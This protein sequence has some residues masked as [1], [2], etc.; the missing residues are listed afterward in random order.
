MKNNITEDSLEQMIFDF[1]LKGR[2]LL[3]EE[4]KKKAFSH[5]G[6]I[7]GDMMVSRLHAI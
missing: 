6:I 4:E 3:S 5:T 2:V 1:V 7:F